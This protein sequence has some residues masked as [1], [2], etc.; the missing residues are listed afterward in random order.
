[1]IPLQVCVRLHRPHL[2]LPPLLLL[3]HLFLPL[4]LHP[5]PQFPLLLML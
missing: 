3:P 1:V 2:H 5:P 4:Q